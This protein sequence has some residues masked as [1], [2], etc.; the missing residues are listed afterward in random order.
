MVA[1]SYCPSTWKMRVGRSE[2]KINLS[3]T[4]QPVSKKN[5]LITYLSKSEC[6]LVR[7]SSGDHIGLWTCQ[8]LSLPLKLSSALPGFFMFVQLYE[9]VVGV[10][11]CFCLSKTDFTVFSWLTLSVH[12]SCLTLLCKEPSFLTLFPL[13]EDVLVLSHYRNRL[14]GFGFFFFFTFCL[15]FSFAFLDSDFT[16]VIYFCVCVIFVSAFQVT[17]IREV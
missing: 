12:F 7:M 11:I 10:L 8:L 15:V 6:C 5:N 14:L 9:C 13:Y 16:F 3:Y 4:S 1:H 17:S 2:F